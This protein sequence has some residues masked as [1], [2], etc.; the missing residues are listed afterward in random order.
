[1]V[2]DDFAAPAPTPYV[3]NRAILADADALMTEFGDD[4]GFEAA[5]RADASRNVGNVLHFARWRQVERLIVL[6]SGNEAVGTVH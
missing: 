5:A 2:F 4:A 1:M 3:A 6:L